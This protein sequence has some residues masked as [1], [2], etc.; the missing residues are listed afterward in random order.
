MNPYLNYLLSELR[1]RDLQDVSDRVYLADVIKL[2]KEAVSLEC[3]QEFVH[4]ALSMDQ[5]NILNTLS[6]NNWAW[7]V[8]ALPRH[9]SEDLHKIVYLRI[10]SYHGGTLG[11][12]Y[13]PQ[14]L[15]PVLQDIVARTVYSAVTYLQVE[16]IIVAAWYLA[17]LDPTRTIEYEDITPLIG[18]ATK[19][20]DFKWRTSP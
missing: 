16:C 19:V 15:F 13:H 7:A 3:F 20:E 17:S 10:R 6:L 2:S 8:F 9:A 5:R 18:G 11:D 4:E 12:R 14:D 1:S